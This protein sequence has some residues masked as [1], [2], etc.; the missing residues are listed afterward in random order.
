MSAKGKFFSFENNKLR[1]SAWEDS[2]FDVL[3]K[4]P[5]NGDRPFA[6]FLDGQKLPAKVAARVRNYVEGFNAADA[7]LIGTAA[8]RKQQEAEDAIEGDRVFRIREG[9]DRLPLFMLDRFLAAGGRAHLNTAAT[10]IGGS[11]A[12]FGFERQMRH[13]RRCERGGR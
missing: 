8:L 7:N 5:A 11:M 10:D 3:E 13:C 9:Y 1:E 2:A 4:L 6:E 12:R